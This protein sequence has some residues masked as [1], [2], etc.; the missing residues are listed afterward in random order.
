MFHQCKI[1]VVKRTVNTDLI[2]EYV[3]DPAIFPICDKLEDNQEFLVFNPWDMPEGMCTSAWADIRSFVLAIAT[4]G[5]FKMMK[6]PHS[7][8]AICTDPFRPVIFN[9]ERVTS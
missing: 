8:L 3:T 7:S 4:G 2:A 1:T 9:I 6:N 5:S